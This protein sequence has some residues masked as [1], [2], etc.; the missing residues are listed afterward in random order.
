VPNSN[1]KG[2]S[3]SFEE[4]QIDFKLP[5]KNSSDQ[6]NRKKSA[7]ST[8]GFSQNLSKRE[9]VAIHNVGGLHEELL[10]EPRGIDKRSLCSRL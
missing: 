10:V 6:G 1:E 8:S 2:H 7:A 5:S 3:G 9:T 4:Y